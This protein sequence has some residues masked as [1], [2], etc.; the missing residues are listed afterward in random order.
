MQ[1]KQA[2]CLQMMSGHQK[3]LCNKL[4][5]NKT[6]ADYW[7]INQAETTIAGL[8]DKEEFEMTDVSDS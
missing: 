5:L 6:P 1:F 3:D 2:V 8:D 4:L 7:Y